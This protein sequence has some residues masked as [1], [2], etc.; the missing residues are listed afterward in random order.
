MTGICTTGSVTVEA[1]GA[2]A[3]TGTGN[4]VILGDINAAGKFAP[5]GGATRTYIMAGSSAQNITLAQVSSMT[6]LTINNAAGVTLGSDLNI[7]NTLTLTAG[8]LD[9]GANL[10]T[11]G[12]STSSI[13]TIARTSGKVI[14]TLK[15][16]FAPAISAT[17]LPIGSAATY[18]EVTVAFTSAPS[19]GGTLA[20]SFSPVW[21]GQNGMT[22][23]D[24]G[25]PL[26]TTIP[27]GVWTLTQ[28]N[29]LTDGTYDLSML[30]GG[31][32]ITVGIDSVRIVKRVNSSSPW[33]V[34][35]LPGTNG[36]YIQRTGLS[37]FSQFSLA[38]PVGQIVPVE[39][40][41]FSTEIIREK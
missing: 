39:L 27:N 11:V 41:R 13:G 15:K 35:G 25:L 6:A 18:N 33:T 34:N 21:G 38:G 32:N 24:N 29:G 7:G 31:F 26:F 1:G 5:L 8:S 36:A 30:P 40:S 22:L 14:G 3:D 4:W 37:G 17:M 2:L 9:A 23:N 12:S 20:A 10:I 28:A 19:V 16:W